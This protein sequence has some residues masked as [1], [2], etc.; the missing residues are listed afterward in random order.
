MSIKRTSLLATAL[1]VAMLAFA[2]TSGAS[3]SLQSCGGGVRAAVV[4]CAK[5]KRI[6]REYVKTHRRSLQGYKCSSKS[7]RGRCALDRKLVLFRLR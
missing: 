3:T 2:G 5:A 1:L 6:A 4:S 7:K